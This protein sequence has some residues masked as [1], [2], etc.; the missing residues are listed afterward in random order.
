LP[1]HVPSELLLEVADIF[2]HRKP[3]KA[4]AMLVETVDPSSPNATCIC[5][6]SAAMKEHTR[7]IAD[8]RSSLPMNEGLR[9]CRNNSSFVLTISDSVRIAA[10][11]APALAP[12]LR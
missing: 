10:A 4:C 1:H 2:K 12:G 3:G 9:A 11:V 8:V 5:G 7:S 6:S